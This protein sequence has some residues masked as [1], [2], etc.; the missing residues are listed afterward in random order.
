MAAVKSVV[1]DAATIRCV[2]VLLLPVVCGIEE[3]FMTACLMPMECFVADRHRVTAC[4]LIVTAGMFFM[5]REEFP[6]FHQ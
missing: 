1:C 2:T 3:G 6:I 4:A 5:N